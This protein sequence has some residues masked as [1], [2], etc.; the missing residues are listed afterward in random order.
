M[1]EPPAAKRK[2]RQGRSQ[3]KS[4]EKP[5]EEIKSEGNIDLLRINVVSKIPVCSSCDVC[6]KYFSVF[7][8]E[9]SLC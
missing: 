2:R 3:I 9:L 5:N 6:Y 1:N 7:L 4:E 8:V